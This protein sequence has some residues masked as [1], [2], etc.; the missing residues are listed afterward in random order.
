MMILSPLR[1]AA[2]AALV[3]PAGLC[4]HASQRP[5]PE[6][7]SGAA[8]LVEVLDEYLDYLRVGPSDEEDD[9]AHGDRLLNWLVW[10]SRHSGR[11]ARMVY[12]GDAALAQAEGARVLEAE[13]KAEAEAEA[14]AQAAP[15]P[16]PAPTLRRALF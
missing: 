10:A 1:R 12:G 16:A 7:L 15:A 11:S 8:T 6:P 14:P 13:A 4:V 2:A 9:P 5:Q 3:L